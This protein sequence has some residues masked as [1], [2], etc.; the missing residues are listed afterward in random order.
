MKIQF[1][2]LLLSTCIAFCSGHAQTPQ[3]GNKVPGFQVKVAFS[4]KATQDLARRKETI[5]VFGYLYGL[6]KPLTPRPPHVTDMGEIGL[7]DFK[8]E[9]KP[10]ETARF[11]ELN[12]NRSALTQIAGPPHVLVNVVSGRRSTHDNLL[13]CSIYQGELRKVQKQDLPIQC[14]LIAE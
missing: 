6:P 13:N 8:T 11:P 3:T 7:G 2:L 4:P 12:V 1:S 10:G 9:V 14:K 5:V